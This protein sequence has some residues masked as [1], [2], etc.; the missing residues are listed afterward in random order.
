MSWSFVT[1]SSTGIRI[2]CFVSVCSCSRY[3]DVKAVCQYQADTRPCCIAPHVAVAYLCNLQSASA[4]RS[5]AKRP[6][7]ERCSRRKTPC[8]RSRARRGCESKECNLLLVL[9]IFVFLSFCFIFLSS[10][11]SFSFPCLS[12]ETL[13]RSVPCRN[14]AYLDSDR[15]YELNVYPSIPSCFG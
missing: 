10:S 4:I 3:Q 14:T 7:K 2:W 11:F 12:A 15:E 5:R 9:V 8:A 6:V 1:V 13:P